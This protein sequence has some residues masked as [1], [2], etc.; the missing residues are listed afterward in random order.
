MKKDMTRM[1]TAGLLACW[2]WNASAESPPSALVTAKEMTLSGKVRSVST[3]TKEMTIETADGKTVILSVNP[4]AVPLGDLKRWDRVRVKYLESVALSIEK[5]PASRPLVLDE[6][7]QVTPAQYASPIM[8]IVDLT[9]ITA[10]VEKVDRKN[11][12]LTMQDLDGNTLTLKAGPA[13]EGFEGV[14]VG[15][16]V[17]AYYSPPIAVDIQRL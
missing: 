5:S 13:V 16:R 6:T 11:R 1:L 4:A 12:T 7:V 8:R 14:K 17:A 2:T 9:A 3:L 10:Q 15:G